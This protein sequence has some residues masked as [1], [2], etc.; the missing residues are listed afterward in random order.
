MA[1]HAYC[2]PYLGTKADDE[3]ADDTSPLVCGGAA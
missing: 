1:F 2:Y 3:L